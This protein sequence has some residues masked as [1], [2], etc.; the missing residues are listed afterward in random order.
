ALGAGPG[1]VGNLV[2]RQAGGRK[3]KLRR[4]EQRRPG[5]LVRGKN[6]AAGGAVAKG[7]AG[8]DRQLIEREMLAGEVQRLVE[9]GLPRRDALARAGVD[10]VERG[11]REAGAGETD[12]RDRLIA[13]VPAAKEAERLRIERLDPERQPVDA[14]GGKTGEARSLGRIGV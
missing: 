8:L 7:G 1:M 5:L 6:L 13:I 12:C 2:R 4:L 3:T 10:Q 11:A 9:L 14:G